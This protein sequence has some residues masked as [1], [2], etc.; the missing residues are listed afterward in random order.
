MVYIIIIITKDEI[1]ASDSVMHY[2]YNAKT[3]KNGDKL[4]QYYNNNYY[5]SNR[6]NSK[7][8]FPHICNTMS[9]IIVTENIIY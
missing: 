7:A 8:K 3:W 6:R 9:S 5:L 1:H 2:Y 4:L